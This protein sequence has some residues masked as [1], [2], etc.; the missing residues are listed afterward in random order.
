MEPKIAML[1]FS[2]FGSAPYPQ[3]IKVAKSVEIVKRLRPD[4]IVD[5]E[6]QADTAVVHER[7]EKEFPFSV[8]KGSANVLIFPSLEAGEYII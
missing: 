2:N 1:S 6:M 3:S 8:L 5:G 4:L 7:L